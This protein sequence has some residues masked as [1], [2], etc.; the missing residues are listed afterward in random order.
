M[1]TI[2]ASAQSELNRSARAG[3][4]AVRAIDIVSVDGQIDHRDVFFSGHQ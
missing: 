4:C 1:M 2:D 3:E